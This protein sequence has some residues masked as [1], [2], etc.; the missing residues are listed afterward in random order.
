M[1]PL[2]RPSGAPFWSAVA[3]VNPEG[4]VWACSP[5]EKSSRLQGVGV[6]RGFSAAPP[7]RARRAAISVVGVGW[8]TDRLM[9]A[10]VG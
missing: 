6:E 4:G 8:G 10:V 2:P 3:G 9:A 5:A 7:P 1:P